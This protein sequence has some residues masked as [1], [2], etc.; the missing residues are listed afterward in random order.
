MKKGI[1]PFTLFLSIFILIYIVIGTKIFIMNSNKNGQ[2]YNEDQELKPKWT[3]VITLWD[4]PYIETGTA[5]NANWLNARVE[6]FE[7]E[8]PGVFI[9]VRRLTPQRAQMY[10]LGNADKDILPDII[11]IPVYEDFVPLSLYEDLRPYFQDE[12]L[13]RILPL[14]QRPVIKDN[15]MKGV[16]IMMGTYALFFNNEML[17]EQEIAIED[18]EVDFETLDR[19]IKRLSYVKKENK[20]EIQYYGFG[21]YNSIYS[22]PI[23]SM[24][25]NQSGKIKEDIGYRYINS[26]VNGES[27]VPENLGN[28]DSSRAIRLFVDEKRIGVFLGNTR[29]LYKVREAQ[30]QGKGFNLGIYSLPMEGKDGLLQDQIVSYGLIKNDDEIK[31]Y[32]CIAFLKSLLSE[33][34]QRELNKIGMFPIIKDIES[35]YENDPEMH[36]LEQNLTSFIYSPDEKFWQI[37]KYEIM[38]ILEPKSE[39]DSDIL[40]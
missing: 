20:K 32:Y 26:W 36:M 14:A 6:K 15:T 25:Y 28:L 12:E 35:I 21:S 34:A 40:D 9:D 5:S 4:I 8:N 39:G 29:T 27:L 13:N 18:S 16:P 3:G 37:H 30:A 23:I 22:K 2:W 24:V 1:K 19:I 10:F 33:E 31:K 38:D 7:R 11:S 17:Q